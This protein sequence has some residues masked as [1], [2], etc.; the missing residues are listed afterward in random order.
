MTTSAKP[1]LIRAL[2]EWILDNKFTPYISL[3]ATVPG[4]KVPQQYVEDGRIVFNLSPTAIR[5]LVMGNRLISFLGAFAN[6][7]HP[8]EVPIRA[9]FTIY[10]KETNQGMEFHLEEEQEDEDEAGAVSDKFTPQSSLS[11]A[12]SKPAEA[13]KESAKKR[14]PF[15]KVVK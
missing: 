6:T 5:E 8:I 2:Y 10:A 13:Q 12:S 4:V 14:A 15:L 7:V 9:I 11:K 3:D 1:Y